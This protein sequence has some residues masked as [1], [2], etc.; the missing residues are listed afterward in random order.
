MTG[1]Q[2]CALPISD[3][4]E[5]FERCKLRWDECESHVPHVR[6]HRDLLALRRRDDAFR[7]QQPAGVDGAV[8]SD[9]AFVLRF[10]ALAPLG[11]RLLVVNLGADIV[12]G[13]FPEPLVAPPDG[14]G[15][16][17]R[18]SSEHPDY[19]GGG[20]SDVVSPD[21]WRIPGHSATVLAPVETTHGS[22][23]QN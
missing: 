8:L 1:V 4:P 12:A 3:D 21:G 14:H 19:G 16:H 18:W 15:W 2:T 20:T 6:L 23:R 7:R 22:D 9:R 13:S 10:S 11:E 5:T 17:V